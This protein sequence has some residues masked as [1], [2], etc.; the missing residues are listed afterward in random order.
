[1]SVK[2]KRLAGDV[3]AVRQVLEK[4]FVANPENEQI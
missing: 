1:M 4:A 3:P 2:D